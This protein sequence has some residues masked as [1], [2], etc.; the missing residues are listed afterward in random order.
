MNRSQTLN[1]NTRSWLFSRLAQA[2]RAGLPWSNTIDNLE[3]EANRNVS[4]VLQRFRSELT[5]GIGFARAGLKSGLLL[6]W[7]SRLLEAAEEG[8]KLGKGLSE[9]SQRYAGE[10]SRQRKLRTGMVF[11]VMFLVLMI[12][13]APLRALLTG[14]ISGLDYLALTVGRIVLF[15]VGFR[16]LSYGW[17]QL[18]AGH[19]DERVLQWLPHIPGIG[20]QIRNRRRHDFLFSLYLLLDA[21]V[22]AIEALGVAANAVH[23]QEIRESYRKTVSDCRNGSTVSEAL[24]AAGLLENGEAVSIVETGEYSGRLVEMIQ[25]HVEQLDQQLTDRA[26]TFAV[27]LPRLL[28]FGALLV[29]VV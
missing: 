4:R 27:W 5:A 21:G 22:P 24:A 9:L 26:E 25:F 17:R 8:G 23:Y 10:A 15:I 18:N 1:S 28:Y 6:P 16:A 20:K 12:L 29:L 2:E 11:P 3:I 14:E 19:G 7:E 13:V